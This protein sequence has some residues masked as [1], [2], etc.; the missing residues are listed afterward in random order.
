MRQQLDVTARTATLTH[1]QLIPRALSDDQL[2]D[3]MTTLSRC[4]Y[5]PRIPVISADSP[6]SRRLA[7]QLTSALIGAGWDTEPQPGSA[8]P[9]WEGI[10]L[11]VE[12][13]AHISHA[14]AL[15][16]AGLKHAGLSVVINNRESAPKVSTLQSS[17]TL[18]PQPKPAE[19]LNLWVGEKPSLPRP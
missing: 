5:R 6:D 17:I 13:T 7:A 18:M 2:R 4:P 3:L 1:Q 8:A 16:V 9:A 19:L 14:A 15:L 12:D 10:V 11:T